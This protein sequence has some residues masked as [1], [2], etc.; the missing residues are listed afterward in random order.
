M[1]ALGLQDV[2]QIYK[3]NQ[4]KIYIN[5][6]INMVNCVQV[7]GIFYLTFGYQG[8]LGGGVNFPPMDF[9]DLASINLKL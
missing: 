4:V 9:S 8:V 1:K 2:C 5:V 3:K 6:Q 7:M